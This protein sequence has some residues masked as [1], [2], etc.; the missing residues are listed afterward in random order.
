LR[1]K[2]YTK[3]VSLAPEVLWSKSKLSRQSEVK[4]NE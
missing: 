1:D 2:N 4:K 3:I